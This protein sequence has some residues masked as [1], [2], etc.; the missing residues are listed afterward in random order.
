MIPPER[1]TV[2]DADLAIII[3]PAGEIVVL[4]VW[5]GVAPDLAGVSAMQV[6]PRRWWLL[7]PGQKLGPIA[8]AL[9]EQ[10]ALTLIGGGLMCATLRGPGWRAQLMIGGLFDAESAGF[11]PGDCAATLLHHTPVWINVVSAHEAHVYF[12]ASLTEDLRALWA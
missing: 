9:G 8:Q 1:A 4:D 7:D 5:S 11:K 6:E 3:A 10:G 2:I 12:A